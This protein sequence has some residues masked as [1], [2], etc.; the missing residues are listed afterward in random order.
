MS[1]AIL[2]FVI[3]LSMSSYQSVFPFSLSNLL[4]SARY[5]GTLTSYLWVR[6]QHFALTLDRIFLLLFRM[7]RAHH[8]KAG[9]SIIKIFRGNIQWLERCT[10]LSSRT[11]STTSSSCR[12]IQQVV[13][14]FWWSSSSRIWNRC[15]SQTCHLVGLPSCQTY[16][17]ADI[18]IASSRSHNPNSY[19]KF[20]CLRC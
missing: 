7:K 12:T 9:S 15:V 11:V 1:N 18:W 17:P 19:R 3:S 13:T 8:V 2:L 14:T 5:F 20:L 16:G 4:S 10:T 6:L